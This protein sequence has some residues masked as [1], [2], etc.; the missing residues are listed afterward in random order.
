[1][2]DRRSVKVQS[3][4]G[5]FRRLWPGPPFRLPAGRDTSLVREVLSHGGTR[6]RRAAEVFASFEHLMALAESGWLGP[7]RASAR[8]S[9]AESRE[10]LCA[11]AARSR[12]PASLAE[13]RPGEPVLVTGRVQSLDAAAPSRTLFWHWE[14]WAYN[15]EEFFAEEDPW[16]LPKEPRYVET[17]YDFLLID[18]NARSAVRVCVDGAHLVAAARL[19][20]GTRIGVLGF[21]DEEVSP[22]GERASVR[23]VPMRHVLRS[24]GSLPLLVLG[25][26]DPLPAPLS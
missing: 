23:E 11:I 25:K 17:A 21:L 6:L 20:A 1:M 5:G 12:G 16:P 7:P 9:M 22:E 24:G 2:P 26:R 14:P 4:P 18:E 3:F 13:F 8:V 19:L 15:A 10:R